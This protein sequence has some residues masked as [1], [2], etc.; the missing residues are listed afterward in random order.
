[1]ITVDVRAA[2]AKYIRVWLDGVDVTNLVFWA[3]LPDQPD[4][5]SEGTVKMYIKNEA[6]QFVL[7]KDG[8]RELAIIQ[9]TG[10][11]RWKLL[12]HDQL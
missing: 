2:I 5:E 4:T 6:G 9:K 12:S 10:R 7:E 8:F 11:V 3:Q 1:M